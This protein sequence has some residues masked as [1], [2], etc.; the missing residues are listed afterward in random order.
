M[1][2]GSGWFGQLGSPIGDMSEETVRARLLFLL[3]SPCR[4]ASGHVPQLEVIDPL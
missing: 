3:I 4:A 2:S 1:S